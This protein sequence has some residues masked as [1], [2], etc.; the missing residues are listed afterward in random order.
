[1]GTA[2]VGA[3]T[4]I[5]NHLPL[6]GLKVKLGGKRAQQDGLQAAPKPKAPPKRAARNKRKATD[7]DYEYDQEAQAQVSSLNQGLQA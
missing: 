2:S 7:D 5:L 4:P 1:M 6:V 3:G